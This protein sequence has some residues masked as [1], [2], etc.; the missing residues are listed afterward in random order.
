MEVV[1]TWKSGDGC[2]KSGRRGGWFKTGK[3]KHSP[4]NSNRR[5][6]WV[7]GKSRETASND[8]IYTLKIK[9]YECSQ[10]IYVRKAL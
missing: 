8:S 9:F 2:D 7:S 4:S 1:E 10:Y 3:G 6:D 5:G